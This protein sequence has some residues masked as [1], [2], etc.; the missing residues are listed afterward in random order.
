MQRGV[1]AA[2]DCLRIFSTT[3]LSLLPPLWLLLLA[4]IAAARHHTWV[5]NYENLYMIS[6]LLH[7]VT[8]FVL[9]VLIFAAAIAALVQ[10]L[11][12]DKRALLISE[13]RRLHGAVIWLSLIQICLSLWVHGVAESGDRVVPAV[14]Q[15]GIRFLSEVWLWRWGCITW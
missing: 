9:I 4:R 7:S 3:V 5:P 6:I 15:L 1:S 10:G 2:K 12:R 11:A 13:R 8:T 14:E